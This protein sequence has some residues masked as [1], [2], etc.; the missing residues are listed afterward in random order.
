MRHVVE[1][2]NWCDNGGENVALVVPEF[3]MPVVA[4][5]KDMV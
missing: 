3:G 5:F 4:D 2:V 1:G